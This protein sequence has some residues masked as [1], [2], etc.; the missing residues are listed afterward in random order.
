MSN[1]RNERI[2]QIVKASVGNIFRDHEEDWDDIKR[3]F[4]YWYCHRPLVSCCSLL[5]LIDGVPPRTVHYDG[6]REKGSHKLKK[7]S[8]RRSCR[9]RTP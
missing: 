5:E 4:V 7:T 1:G 9:S 6:R 8:M 2:E 3:R